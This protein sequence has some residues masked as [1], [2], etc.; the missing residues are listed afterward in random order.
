MQ[1]YK[2]RERGRPQAPCT[3]RQMFR[4][5]EKVIEEVDRTLSAH[6]VF[7]AVA[8]SLRNKTFSRLFEEAEKTPGALDRFLSRVEKDQ[9]RF[10][11][12]LKEFKQK[13]VEFDDEHGLLPVQ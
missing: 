10:A 6:T 9:E 5:D 4:R 13:Q 1:I 2:D 12:E 7:G 3:L 11:R 8:K